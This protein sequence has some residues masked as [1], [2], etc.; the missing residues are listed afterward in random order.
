MFQTSIS[1]FFVHGPFQPWDKSRPPKTDSGSCP[2][3]CALCIYIVVLTF[4]RHQKHLSINQAH[5]SHNPSPGPKPHLLATTHISDYNT[6]YLPLH[7]T[8]SP[9]CGLESTKT[10]SHATIGMT[11]PAARFG[12]TT[13]ALITSTQTAA[14]TGIPTSSTREILANSSPR[15]RIMLSHCTPPYQ[16]SVPECQRPRVQNR[17][18]GVSS[19]MWDNM[20]FELPVRTSLDQLRSRERAFLM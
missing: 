7:I 18:A 15:R 10:S 1:W 12:C 6:E 8:C 11:R 9:S 4:L 5:Q 17:L 2:F 3:L 14:I 16:R 13:V 19:G 20:L